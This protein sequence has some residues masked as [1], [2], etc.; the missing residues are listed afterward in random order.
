ML[1]DVSRAGR[2][3]VD[4]GLC[5]CNVADDDSDL[6]GAVDCIDDCPD[7]GAVVTVSLERCNG[8]DD[9]CDGTIDDR[10]PGDGAGYRRIIST[11]STG[12]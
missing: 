10:I 2:H 12:T 5:G 7:D 6:D 4:P 11:T 8:V 3:G 1:C 9:D